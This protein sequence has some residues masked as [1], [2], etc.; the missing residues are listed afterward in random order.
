MEKLEPKYKNLVF[1]IKDKCRVCYTCVRECPVKAIKIINGQAEVIQERCIAC[2]NCTRVCS[3]GA[4]AFLNST[5]NVLSLL[6]S[7]EK[8]AALLAPSFASE[9]AEID[10]YKV[11]VGMLRDL[12]FDKVF[13]VAF[14]ADLVA[15]EY[16]KF[17][18]SE[19]SRGYISSDC[20]AIVSFIEKY[21]SELVED[22][23][24]VVSPMVA[25]TRYIR[26][27]EDKDMKLVFIGP[28]I[29]KKAESSEVDEL[30][31]FLELREMFSRKSIEPT[32][33]Q[34]I[35][36]DPP[37]G[38]KGAIFP[39][40][41]GLLET[42]SSSNNGLERKIIVAEGRLD[43][44]EA[45]REYEIGSIENEHLELLCCEGCIMGPGTSKNGMK[46]AR[47]S[48]ILNYVNQKLVKDDYENWENAMEE[49]LDLDLSRSFC[50]Q[51]QSIPDPQED[52]IKKVLESMNK[53][54]DKDHLNC[55]A[56][57]YDTCRNHAIAIIKGLAETEMCLPHAIDQL[58]LSICDLA[59]SNEKL[60]SVQQVLK[61]TEKLAHMGQLSAGIAHELNNPLGVVIM[62]AN[63]LLEELEEDNELHADMKLIAEQAERC[64]SIV[65]GLLNFARKNQVN[66]RETD[67]NELI[68]ISLDSVIK[69]ENIH[70]ITDS[71]LK[72]PF[73]DLDQEQMVQV[74][75]NLVRNAFEA[76]PGGGELNINLSD[77]KD[78]IRIEITDT[79]TGISNSDLQKVFEPFFTTKG[80]GKG[81]GLGLA[82][83][84]GV[85]KMHK[86]KID[87]E[88]NANPADGPTFTRFI[89]QLPRRIN[90]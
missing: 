51:D 18:Y 70:V 53:M 16:R 32:N 25:M 11:L 71:S 9:F 81:T 6:E 76:M 34:A 86:G 22:L 63:I 58:H 52:E 13:E 44:Q 68:R 5:S 1:S 19:R 17:M 28:C 3:Q 79:G 30:L 73:A 62:Y 4:K 40:S 83:A 82:T 20:P 87:V 54:T 27:N 47:R 43:F 8:V 45:I 72:N 42:L 56:C 23:V 14:G 36:F 55:G 75:S 89:I 85:V 31:T 2:G 77:N 33:V 15:R 90:F 48:R 69:P 59:I 26:K 84:Y 88:S 41:R 24:P 67:L 66:H 10:D 60:M 65:G 46:F 7:K 39:I 74:I 29:A 50:Q 38:A 37:V 12:G 21:H 57:G 49:A 61:Q 35:E 80:I 78:H 64:K